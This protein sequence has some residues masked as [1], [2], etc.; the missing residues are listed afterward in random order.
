MELAEEESRKE[1]E[2]ELGNFHEFQSVDE[3]T[4]PPMPCVYVYYDR[5]ERAVYVGETDNLRRRHRQ[6]HENDKWCIPRIVEY[7]AYVET[8]TRDQRKSLEKLLIQF[9]RRNTVFNR[10]HAA[11]DRLSEEDE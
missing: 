11:P 8:R 4:M 9:L 10:K 7:G 3:S 6:H 1:S 5:T 2:T